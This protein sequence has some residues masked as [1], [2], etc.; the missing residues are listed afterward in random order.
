MSRPKARELTERE[1][2]LMHVFWEKGEMTIADL[3]E[4]LQ[5]TGRDL[6]YTTVAT[7]V[8]I[9]VE[10]DFL[11]QTNDMRPFRFRPRKSFKDVSGR[12]V[13]DLVE[14]VFGGSRE[15]L[16]LRLMEQRKPSKAERD[17]LEKFLTPEH[18][19]HEQ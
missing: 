13:S 11:R 19:K 15:A 9:L 14:K 18:D 7:L 12:L 8:K 4:N 2:E 6:A 17:V 5:A 10:K 3:Q 16:L 1:L